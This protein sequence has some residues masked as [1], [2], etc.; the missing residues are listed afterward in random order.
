M[1]S[2]IFQEVFP[3]KYWRGYL[4]AGIIG[5]FTWALMAYAKTHTKLID[6]VYPYITRMVQSFL[7]PWS[8]S[9]DVVVWQLVVMLFLVALVALVVMTIVWRWNIIQIIGWVLAAVSLVAFLHTGIYGLNYYAG[10]LSADIRL[11]LTEYN[12]TELENAAVYYRDLANSLSHE[13]PRDAQGNADYEE[14][15]ILAEK[16]G[17]GFHNLTYEKGMSVFA[18]DTTPV[19]KLGFSDYYTSVGITGVHMPL[20]GEASVNPQTPC[21]GLPFTMSHEM[22]HRMCIAQEQDANF[23]AF[24]ACDAHSD[25]QF[26]YSGYFMAYRYCLNALAAINSQAAARVSAGA[27]TLLQRDLTAY[28][29]FFDQ[30]R[31]EKAAEFADTV[32]DTYIKVSGN[33]RGVESYGDVVQLLVSWHIQEVVLPQQEQ[34]EEI[35]FDP[36]AVTPSGERA[37]EETNG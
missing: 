4:T 33:E 26:R 2:C 24:L 6:M 12:L 11:E 16:A 25:P 36:Y 37:T 31:N 13:I 30:K 18:G 14:F 9:V 35:E 7:A 3:L 17:E 23:S 27:D 29:T 19:K 20:T 21:V 5:F 15:E 34:Q 32:N 22:A 1:D 10:P 28:S 8:A